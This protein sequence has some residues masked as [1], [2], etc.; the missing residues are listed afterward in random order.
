LLWTGING[1]KELEA[2]RGWLWSTPI[3][4][5]ETRERFIAVGQRKS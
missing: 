1:M 2:S 5:P 4:L 3:L